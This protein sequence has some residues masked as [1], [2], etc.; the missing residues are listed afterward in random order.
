M[1]GVRP[2]PAHPISQGYACLKGMAVP[3]KIT[4]YMAAGLPSICLGDQESDLATLAVGTGSGIMCQS[5]GQFAQAVHA[6]A[7]DAELRARMGASALN[8]ATSRYS[9]GECTA[10]FMEV[11]SRLP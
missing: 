1:V 4:A 9:R 8:A 3:S 6:L 2:D 10:S 7:T 5:P 11:L